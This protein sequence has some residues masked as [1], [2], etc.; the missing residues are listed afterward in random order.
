MAFQK[1]TFV[2]KGRI[3]LGH[4]GQNNLQ[5]IGNTSKLGLSIDEES[6]ELADY[7]NAGGGVAD[8]L[9]RIKDVKVALTLH[10]LNAAN[11]ALALFGNANAIDAGTVTNANRTANKGALVRLDHLGA[12]AVVVTNPAGTTTYALGADYQ[13]TGA[14]L[15]IPDN[16]G[17][18]DNAPIKVSYAYG[19]QNLIEAITATGQE[20]TLAF[21]GLNEADSGK[22][23]VVDL[24]R[25][26]FAPTKSLDLIDDD[27]SKLE[28][29]GKLLKDDG[30]P[31]GT[32][33]YFRYEFQ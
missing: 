27:Y 24:W 19:A 15:L 28:L 10:N 22:P 17:I 7:E 6:K 18:A 30:R 32:S 2:G 12:T 14:G 23:C 33:Q 8:A 11:L 31:L 9:S 26:R 21:D 29:E 25:V 5:R 3:Y 1:R 13:V 16:S 4:F 20:Y